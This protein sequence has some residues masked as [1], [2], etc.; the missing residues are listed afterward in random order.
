MT[1]TVKLSVFFSWSTT[2]DKAPKDVNYD[3][4]HEWAMGLPVRVERA[5]HHSGL[6]EYIYYGDQEVIEDLRERIN[7]V[8][9]RGRPFSL[10]P[11][12]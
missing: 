3:I 1:T 2:Y 4:A 5:L 9:A 7:S 10:W 8:R 6:D 12:R 11:E